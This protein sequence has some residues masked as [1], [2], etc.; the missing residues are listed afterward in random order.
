[1]RG[2]TLQGAGEGGLL[3]FAFDP[4]QLHLDLAQH[5]AGDIYWAAIR[6]P[7]EIQSDGRLKG[8][9]VPLIA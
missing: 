3:A 7:Q 2:R 5:R 1:M 4:L 6:A 8:L 9:S